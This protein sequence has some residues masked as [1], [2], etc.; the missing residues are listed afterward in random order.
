MEYGSGY[1]ASSME[2][3]LPN[4]KLLPLF[5][6]ET[7][8]KR[9]KKGQM[10]YWQGERAEGFYYLKKG[11]VSIFLSSVNGTKK[12]LAIQKPGSVFGE[13]AFFDELPRVS[14]ARA[15]EDSQIVVITKPV[16]L[17]YFREQPDTALDL[18]RYLSRTVRMLSAQVDH[19]AFMQADRRIAQLLLNLARE[20][21]D[22][23][24]VSVCHEAIGELAGVSRVTVSKVLSGFAKAGWIQTGY[25]EIVV[26]D[27]SAL[28]KLAFADPKETGR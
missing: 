10:I 5:A 12:T 27:E 2:K 17:R 1:I 8:V 14:S 6:R 16:L 7:A 18:L 24:T 26:L 21:G 22:E 19:M 13:A 25:R 23:L 11:T 15:E 4:S 28:K 20:K 3:N 9:V